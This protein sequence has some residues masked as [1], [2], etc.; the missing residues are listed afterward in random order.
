ME[1]E[2]SMRYRTYFTVLLPPV[3][4]IQTQSDGFALIQ[5]TVLDT[6]TKH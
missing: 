1:N 5:P 3:E 2:Q 6:C 4:G